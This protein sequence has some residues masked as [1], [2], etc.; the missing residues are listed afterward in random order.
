MNAS[1]LIIARDGQAAVQQV[2]LDTLNGRVPPDRG[3]ILSLA[4]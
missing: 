4:E 2:Y 1:Q 3:H